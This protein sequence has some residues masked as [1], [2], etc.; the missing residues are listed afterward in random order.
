MKTDEALDYLRD[1][2]HMID[3]TIA[4]VRYLRFGEGLQWVV[5]TGHNDM[6]VNMRNGYGWKWLEHRDKEGKLENIELI[7]DMTIFNST[8]C[9]PVYMDSKMDELYK[10]HQILEKEIKE[11]KYQMKLNR[12]ESDF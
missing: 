11:K 12:I 1:K 2:Y 8:F 7:F 5:C 4:G 9:E 10:K 3:T 6:L